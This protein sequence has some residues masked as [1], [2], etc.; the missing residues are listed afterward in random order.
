MVFKIF[1]KKK[2]FF[3]K[4]FQVQP[5]SKNVLTWVKLLFFSFIF[6]FSFIAGS[7]VS[8]KQQSH[9]NVSLKLGVGVFSFFRYFELQ[10]LK[11]G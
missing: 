4:T 10:H 5:V 1:R 11:N 8:P 7:R 2:L 9:G 3:E 6:L